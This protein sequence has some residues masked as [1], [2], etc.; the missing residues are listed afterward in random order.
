VTRYVIIGAGAVGVTLGAELG[1]IGKEVVLVGRGRQ[2]DLLRAGRVRYFTPV[3][4]QTVDAPAVSGPSELALKA[5]DVLLIATK[6]QQ[7]PA[8]IDEWAWQPI[9]GS[10]RPAAE[11]VAAGRDAIR[12]LP[13]E[14][15]L[16]LLAS[17]HAVVDGDR[18]PLSKA[19]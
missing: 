2:L 9:S 3:G 4:A 11:S 8:V 7:A 5:S 17:A 1:A 16:E 10:R 14:D 12:R 6:T 19:A 13:R 15:R 18:V